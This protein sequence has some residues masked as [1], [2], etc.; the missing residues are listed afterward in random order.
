VK[1]IPTLLAAIALLVSSSLYAQDNSDT[2]ETMLNNGLKLIVKKD[3]RAPVV[4]SQ[5]WYKVG[6][7]YE[8]GGITGISHV[9]EHMM[10]KGTKEYPAGEFSKIIAANGGQENAGT[11]R[12]YTFYYQQL[13]ADKLAISFKLEADRMQNLILDKDQFTKE[14]Q[15]VMEERRMRTDDN[16][17]ALTYERFQA[18]AHIT[19][20]YHHPIIGWM[21]D[22]KN[23]KV[24]DLKDWYQQW[25]A[26]NNAIVIVVGDVNPEQVVE[27][28][29]KY[30]GP[31]PPSPIKTLKPQKAL[32]PLGKRNLSV[33]A[34]ANLPWLVLG[35]NT[36][37]FTVATEK[38]QTYAL[39]VAAG[40]LDAGESSRL[41][42]NLVR[43]DQIATSASAN[44]DLFSRIAGLFVLT[45]TPNQEHSVKDLKKALLAQIE[46]LQKKPVSQSELG[47]VKAQIIAQKVYSQDSMLY[48]GMIMG[49]LESVGLPWNSI[50]E[51]VKQVQK[52]TPLQVQ[53]VAKKYLTE[54]RLTVAELVPQKI[55]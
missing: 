49:S 51:Y 41:Q 30:F 12:D 42:K 10:F 38:W 8:P 40:I 37:S 43:G 35:Y 18:T 29:K 52:I 16:P 17:Q 28:A 39:D 48:Q 46:Q 14:L 21:D 20:P 44:Y 50:D 13:A 19:N 15:V 3:T 2:Y 54:N 5:V 24:S 26:P 1:R 7:S 33:S 9:L 4:V 23:L 55:S 34:P 45:A 36:P 53:Q 47:R 27:L 31:I 22:L 6:S 11:N 25:Y 32:A